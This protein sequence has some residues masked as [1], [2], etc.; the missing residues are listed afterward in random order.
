MAQEKYF[1]DE[2]VYS[3]FRD[4]KYGY[5]RLFI[6][7]NI[8]KDKVLNDENIWVKPNDNKDFRVLKKE[9]S[10][11][12]EIIIVYDISEDGFGS[13]MNSDL[14]GNSEYHMFYDNSACMYYIKNIH[15]LNYKQSI[16]IIKEKIK[17]R[18]RRGKVNIAL[19]SIK[20]EKG[21]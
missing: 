6:T 16:P 14:R 12:S 21:H 5:Y 13:S 11:S 1:N 20:D 8:F 18:L 19:N 2:P 9:I 3:G 17:K 7:G 15:N 10:D 4:D